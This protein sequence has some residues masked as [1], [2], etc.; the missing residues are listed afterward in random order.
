MSCYVCERFLAELRLFERFDQASKYDEDRSGT[1][2]NCL[3]GSLFAIA[4]V[5]G[6]DCNLIAL[7]D[8]HVRCMY[9]GLH[10]IPRFFT[11]LGFDIAM[12]TLVIRF[13]M[14]KNKSI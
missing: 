14:V 8:S 13:V 2:R 10:A 11:S 7:V 3:S 4:S 12:I 5:L 6:A 9:V 1:R